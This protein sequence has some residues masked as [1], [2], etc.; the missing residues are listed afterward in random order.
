MLIQPKI[1]HQVTRPEFTQT[2]VVQ[3]PVVNQV[4][5]TS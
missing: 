2:L 5:I 3:H 4:E 1:L